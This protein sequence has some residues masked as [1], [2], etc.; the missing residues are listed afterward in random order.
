MWEYLSKE[1]KKILNKTNFSNYDIILIS[2]EVHFGI[3]HLLFALSMSKY[4]KQNKEVTKE[5]KT[6]ILEKEFKGWRFICL[7]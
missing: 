6:L 2:V 1:I 7:I 4:I 3:Q 5:F